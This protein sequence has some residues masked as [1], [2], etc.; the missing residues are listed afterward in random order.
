M[1][2]YPVFPRAQ[3]GRTFSF[4][5][6]SSGRSED[7]CERVFGCFLREITGVT[8]PMVNA[9]MKKYPTLRLLFAHYQKS[10]CTKGELLLADLM[11]SDRKYQELNY[12][13]YGKSNVYVDRYGITNTQQW[14]V[15]WPY[16][17]Q[18]YLLFDYGH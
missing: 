15:N 18:T 10:P 1:M 4:Y 3:E 9:I 14:E 7:T 8:V 2:I 5:T 17:I 12:V 6:E 13:D 11:V 16:P